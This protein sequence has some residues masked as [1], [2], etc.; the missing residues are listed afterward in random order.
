MALYK[1]CSTNNL[2]SITY[3][4][5]CHFVWTQ[6]IKCLLSNM[7]I[8]P[9]YQVQ[10]NKFYCIGPRMPAATAP[11]SCWRRAGVPSVAG[12]GSRLRWRS[13]SKWQKCILK[14]VVRNIFHLVYVDR[15]LL[16]IDICRQLQFNFRK[17]VYIF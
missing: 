1:L 16:D 11:T 7:K 13:C 15:P 14:F 6:N 2:I 4:Y 17:D 8:F 3:W 9:N 5:L 10:Q 12:R